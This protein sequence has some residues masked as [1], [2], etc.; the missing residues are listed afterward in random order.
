[1]S[2]ARIT[3]N[4]VLPMPEAQVTQDARKVLVLR[5][6]SKDCYLDAK[7]MSEEAGAKLDASLHESRKLINAQLESS[8]NLFLK[9]IQIMTQSVATSQWTGEDYLRVMNAFKSIVHNCMNSFGGEAAYLNAGKFCLVAMQLVRHYTNPNVVGPEYYIAFAEINLNFANYAAHYYKKNS[10]EL[11]PAFKEVLVEDLHVAIGALDKALHTGDLLDMDFQPLKPRTDILR[12]AS[13]LFS[14]ISEVYAFMG[15][16]SKAFDLIIRAIKQ[17]VYIKED[18]KVS[19]DFYMVSD[20]CRKASV[21]SKNKPALHAL[22]DLMS[23][24]FAGDKVINSLY[25]SQ[26]ARI[27]MTNLQLKKSDDIYLMGDLF[28]VIF[29]SAKYEMLPDS[30]LK[31][32]LRDPDMN[33][34]MQTLLIKLFVVEANRLDKD[35]DNLL[36]AFNDCVA[37][38]KPDVDEPA[39]EVAPAASVSTINVFNEMA[40]ALISVG[41]IADALGELAASPDEK[42]A[43]KAPVEPPAEPAKKP[44]ASVSKINMHNE[45]GGAQST[46]RGMAQ[47]FDAIAAKSAQTQPRTPK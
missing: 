39:P 1:M 6:Q 5:D 31:R 23:K 43:A 14:D 28:R 29:D 44:A 37:G 21:L 42:P 41:G 3:L 26:I 34:K 7:K 18:D 47:A 27:C 11:V 36:A 4:S 25:F 40:D 38:P 30:N 32:D 16:S 15:Y 24:Y 9:S 17:R 46:V 8:S 10:G 12:K 22:F 45:K 20:F 2:L 35:G 33:G 19:E 13:M